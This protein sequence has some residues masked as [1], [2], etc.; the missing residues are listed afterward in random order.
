MFPQTALHAKTKN[1]F[2]QFSYFDSIHENLR[3]F[4]CWNILIPCKTNTYSQNEALL[5][6]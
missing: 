5:L 3:K 2:H 4:D 1:I 6:T